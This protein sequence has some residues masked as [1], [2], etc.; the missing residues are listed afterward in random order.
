MLEYFIEAMFSLGLFFNILLFIPQALR[1]LREK[2]AQGV[3]LVTFLGF[4]L[5]QLFTVLHGYL[6]QDYL[7]ML[8][9]LLSFITCGWV[10]YLTWRY[11]KK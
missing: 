7:L 2:N 9:F 8:G 4:N 1:L 11:Q 5:M 3:S 6:K 10:S